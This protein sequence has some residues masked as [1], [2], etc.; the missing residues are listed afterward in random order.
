MAGSISDASR[1]LARELHARQ[2]SHPTTSSGESALIVR[3]IVGSAEGEHA[4][5]GGSEA[6]EGRCSGGRGVGKWARNQG[7]ATD[8]ARRRAAR[9]AQTPVARRNTRST[10]HSG[11][12]ADN[13]SIRCRECR[14]EARQAEWYY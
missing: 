10:K 8:G 12:K 13:Y 7:G 11:G 14:G 9:R 4:V 6:G 2:L 3:F 5:A 1:L